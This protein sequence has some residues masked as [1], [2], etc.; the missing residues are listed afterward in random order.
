MDTCSHA[1]HAARDGTPFVLEA[2][3][4][5]DYLSQGTILHQVHAAV[6]GDTVAMLGLNANLPSHVDVN[7]LRQAVEPLLEAVRA[8][9]LRLPPSLVS[10]CPPH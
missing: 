6:V 2:N 1:G 7:E 4:Q 5:S 3:T 9:T 8:R 10:P